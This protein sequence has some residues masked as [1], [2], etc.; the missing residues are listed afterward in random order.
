MQIQIDF[1]SRLPVSA[2]LGMAQ[3]DENANEL[4]KREVDAAIRAVALSMPAFTADDVNAELERNHQH[5]T[6][7]NNSALAPRL[8]EV[9]KVLHY[10]RPT[11]EVRRSA[12]LTSKGHFLR[13]WQSNI[14]QPKGG[15]VSTGV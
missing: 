13:V 12:R 2:Q 9:S 15:L 11:D 3:A 6:T 1:E 10:M 5:F 7:H 8:K 14:F 4:W